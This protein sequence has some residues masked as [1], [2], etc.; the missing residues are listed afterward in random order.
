MKILK[1]GGMMQCR[2]FTFDNIQIG[3][4]KP[5]EIQSDNTVR[6]YYNYFE[7]SA[8]ETAGY[9]ADDAYFYSDK[10]GYYE[11]CDVITAI[12]FLYEMYDDGYGFAEINGDI[13]NDTK[14][15]AWL[16]H[17]L[18][19]SF[20]MK[21]R[22]RLWDNAETMAFSRMNDYKVL[23]SNEYLNNIIPA[24]L[25]FAA[26]GTELTDLL[27]IINGTNSL[28]A[29]KVEPG[30][31]PDDV[32][33]CKIALLRYF[34]KHPE[35]ESESEV[36]QLV[37]KKKVE[38]EQILILEDE[39]ADI[40]KSTLILPARVVLYLTAE[41]RGLDFWHVWY[42]MKESVYHDED[43]KV[44]ASEELAS[45]RKRVIEKPIPPI[46]TSDFLRQVGSLQFHE[47][48]EELKGK[49]DY[50]ISDDERLF[51]WDGTDEVR[52][53]D[54][55]D[56]WLKE[57]AERHKEIEADFDENRMDQLTFL[58]ELITLMEKV[59][60][61]YKRIYLFEDTYYEFTNHWNCKEYWAAVEL[62]RQL[63]EENKED[64][65]VIETVRYSWDITSRNVTHNIARLRLKRYISVM[66]NKKLRMQYFGF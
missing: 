45:A 40:A 5:L 34:E 17:I 52:I 44:Y 32:Y 9:R 19:T 43:M 53:S 21:K 58:L 56:A 26:G 49:P 33:R 11:F 14:Y 7:D 25:S 51:W 2:A 30:T 60:Q 18:H 13:I 24:G 48:P 36:W 55:V 3:L 47:T 29:N 12:H 61:Y 42:D 31:Y 63:Y 41:I 8:W 46:R 27:F 37:K 59:E 4:L 6:F 23:F 28:S 1:Y 65:K 15:V 57:L 54:G 50:Y 38:R 62:L 35:K 16:N 39:L 20:S 64:G 66:A 22:F 10:I